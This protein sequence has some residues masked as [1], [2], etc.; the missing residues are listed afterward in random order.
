MSWTD[1]RAV[2][3]EEYDRLLE[4]IKLSDRE[5]KRLSRGY[6]QLACAESEIVRNHAAKMLEPPKEGE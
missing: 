4:R 2:T 6:E 1:S 5:N 3:E